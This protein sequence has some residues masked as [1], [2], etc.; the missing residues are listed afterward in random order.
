MDGP[1][2]SNQ[3]AQF[4]KPPVD[5]TKQDND[6]PGG[7]KYSA[8][9]TDTGGNLW[10][11]TGSSHDLMKPNVGAFFGEMWEYVGTQIYVG[12]LNNYWTKI[13]P[14]AV[15]P[16]PRWGAVTWTA[17]GNFWLFGGQDISGNFL[18]D[19]WNY[20][21]TNNTWTFVSS[22]PTLNGVYGVK[23]TPGASNFPGARWGAT[24][25]I[26]PTTGT[27]WLF[28]GY[29][30]GALPGTPPNIP[31]L[32]N[33][34]WKYSGGQWTWVSGSN[35]INQSGTYG[36]LGVS[37]A[38][39]VPGG[40]QGVVSWMDKSGNFWIFGGFQLSASQPNAFND[41]WEF[42][43]GNS[44][45]AWISGAN[46]VNQTANF[47]TQGVAAAT[48]VP[49]ARWIPASWSDSS[50]NFWLFGGLGYDATANGTLADLW[51]FKGGQWIWVKGPSSANQSGFY[52]IQPNP[53]VW[54]HV[55]NYPGSRWGAAYWAAPNGFWMFGGEGFDS[56]S[57]VG[58][59]LLNDLW[60]YLPYP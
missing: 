42:T 51:E 35:V 6:T 32:L 57:G 54:P 20:N 45:W 9:W 38:A 59:A 16:T 26:D 14:N 23:G 47:G 28:G 33:D 7:S 30:F 39:N 44:Q 13:P 31:G 56:A 46:F 36:Q 15:V 5:H 58:D 19:L 40:R 43:V 18:N 41:L 3:D 1:N 8:S 29:G 55:I 48:N 4:T 49:G 10:L 50:G 27:V 11:F 52:G 2:T 22:G 34:L 21:P 17:G 53:I 25:K 24:A 60:R 12:G 37:A